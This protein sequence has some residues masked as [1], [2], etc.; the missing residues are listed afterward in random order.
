LLSCYAEEVQSLISSSPRQIG[1]TTTKSPFIEQA[2]ADGKTYIHQP[3]E[4]Y[5]EENHD[6]WR[7]LFARMGDSWQR[8]AHAG[9]LNG[10]VTLN[11][12]AERVPRLDDVNKFLSPLTNFRALPVSGYIPAYTFFDCLSRREFPTTVTV[13]DQ[14][15]LDYL[16]EPDIFHDVAGHVPMHT[17]PSFADA[18]VRFGECAHLAAHLVAEVRDPQARLQRLTSMFKGLAR[19]F[20]FTVEFGLMKGPGG[21]PKA[22][23]AGLLSSF[24]ELEHAC[25]SS[26]VQRYPLEM[27]WVINQYF[28]IDHYQPLLFVIDSFEHLYQL[29]DELK[30]WMKAGKLDNL[31]PGEPLMSDGDVQSFLDAALSARK[32]QH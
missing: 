7:T 16:P 8:H 23:G 3:Y 18:L 11:L 17:D 28:E 32:Q 26:V 25:T 15:T 27:G 29:A 10:L 2:R 1:L 21:Q 30:V 31:S 4:L 9:F 19:F 24:G 5:S 6:A 13:R 14:T 12:D 22:Y 20:W